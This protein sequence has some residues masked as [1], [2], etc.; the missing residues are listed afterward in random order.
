[1]SSAQ[2]ENRVF[3]L[4]LGPARPTVGQYLL[5]ANDATVA[6]LLA[7]KRKVMAGLDA[8]RIFEA[9]NPPQDE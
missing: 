6:R 1:M 2:S 3:R 5:H 8:Q 7:A 4:G 9:Q